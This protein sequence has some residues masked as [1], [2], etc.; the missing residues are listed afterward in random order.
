MPLGV[1][2]LR[3]ERRQAEN[4]PLV[5]PRAAW[6]A[7]RCQRLS[8]RTLTS[9]LTQGSSRNAKGKGRRTRFTAAGPTLPLAFLCG[10]M[11][12]PCPGR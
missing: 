6:D 10:E 8:V 4:A 2:R 11:P 9:S 5:P 7:W 1:K 12:F 3:N